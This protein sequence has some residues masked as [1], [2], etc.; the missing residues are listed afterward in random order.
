ME[1]PAAG[2]PACGA[3]NLAESKFCGSCGAALVAGCPRCG[4]RNPAGGSFC[5]ECG[6]ALGTTALAP[7]Y[8]SPTAYTPHALAEK[9]RARSAELAG[10]RKIITVLFA[11]VAGF[12]SISE[13]LDPE[14][15][16]V[17]MQRGFALMLEA[18]HRYEGT[19]SQLLGDGLLALFGAPIA[20]ED[21]ARRAMGAREIGNPAQVWRSHAVRGAVLAGRGDIEGA[22]SAYGD[23]LAG[24][25]AVAEGLEDPELRATMLGSAEVARI[26]EG[27]RSGREK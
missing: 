16:R 17:M 26:R 20:H 18:V 22:T 13:R 7:G 11:D 2:C 27:A 23:A 12:T 25:E 19:V 10:E 1:R 21:H 9:I 5:T 15:T 4:H 3:A 6:A 24:A 8:A 14:E